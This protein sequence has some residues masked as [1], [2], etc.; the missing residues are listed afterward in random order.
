M[1]IY[2]IL[3]LA[4][5]VLATVHGACKGLVWQIASLASIV[6]SYFVAIRFREPVAQLIDAEPPWNNF[7][8][9]LALYVGTSLVIW[10]LFRLVRSTVDR[11]RL[12]GFDH[13][14]GALFGAI[15]G[16]IFCVIITLFAVTLLGDDERRT[17]VESHSGYYIARILN[18]ADAV[19]P[20]ELHDVLHPYIHE[21]DERLER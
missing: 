17:I 7:A 18:R 15:K 16:V 6:A 10:L 1:E 12:T 4:V 14:I 19:M 5:L 11:L 2:D 21:L 20:A 13:Q 9:M 8:A 3:M